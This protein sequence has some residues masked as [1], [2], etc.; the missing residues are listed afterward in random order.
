MKLDNSINFISTGKNSIGM[1]TFVMEKNIRYIDL[2]NINKYTKKQI[3]SILTSVGIFTNPNYKKDT[4][5]LFLMKNEVALNKIKAENR[6]YQINS[7][8]S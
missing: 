5:I 3:F 7:I 4:L 8:L 1:N 6:Q 2:D